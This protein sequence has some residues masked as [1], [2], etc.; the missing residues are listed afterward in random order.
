MPRRIGPM[1]LAGDKLRRA[2]HS[3]RNMA[4]SAWADYLDVRVRL[5]HEWMDQGLT[6]IECAPEFDVSPE[7]IERIR[8]TPPDPPVPGSSRDQLALW[9]ARCLALEQRAN[10][11]EPTPHLPPPPIHSEV[12]GLLP[13]EDPLRCG[14]QHWTD[15]PPAGE[16]HPSCVHGRKA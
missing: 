5:V 2:G 9:K 10:D 3:Q 4:A 12:R 1:V 13:H 15:P 6:S 8:L 16:H 7:E 14:C 11:A